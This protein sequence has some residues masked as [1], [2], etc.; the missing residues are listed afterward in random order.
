M[1]DANWK[2]VEVKIDGKVVEGIKALDYNYPDPRIVIN[3]I[4]RDSVIN[5][6]L[7]RINKFYQGAAPAYIIGIDGSII[8]KYDDDF[9]KI[10]KELKE[11]I[12]LR[13]QQIISFYDR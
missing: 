8:C 7:E 3:A 13:R 12:E 1:K 2:D 9:N 10:I 4:Q 5:K 11:Q 6:L